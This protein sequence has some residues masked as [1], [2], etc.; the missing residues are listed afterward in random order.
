MSI[1]PLSGQ[2]VH[3][4]E[5]TIERFIGDGFLVLFNDPLPCPDPA[6]TRD[7]DGG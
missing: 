7:Q 2:L 5:G 6:A 1:T 4:Y 3:K